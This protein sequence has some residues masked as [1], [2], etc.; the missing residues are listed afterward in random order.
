MNDSQQTIS[1][2]QLYLKL[3]VYIKPL[4][5]MFAIGIAGNIVFALTQPAFAEL[6]RYITNA[7]G[8]DPLARWIVPAALI[9]IF[10]VRGLGSFIGDYGFARVAFGVVHAL[11]LDLFNHIT[12]LPNSAI[13][14]QNS[15]TLVSRVTYDTLQ[16]TDTVT[17]AIKTA[18]REGAIVIVLMAYLL[19]INW[20]ATSVFILIAPLVLWVLNKISKRLRKLGLRIQNSMGDLTHLCA[21]MINNFRVMRVFGGEDYE[22]KRFNKGSQHNARQNIKRRTTAAAAG[23]LVQLLAVIALAVLVFLAL[24]LMKENSAGEILAYITAAAIMPQSMRKLG[25][26]L[27]SI[28]K[29][30]AAADSIFKQLDEKQEPDLGTGKTLSSLSG[31][32]QFNDVGFTYHNPQADA[33]DIREA[34]QKIA[35]D[36]VSFTVKA[37]ET[38]ALVG[39]SGSGKTTLINLIPRFLCHQSGTITIDNHTLEDISLQSLRRQIALVN[40]NITLFNDTLRNN[41]AYGDM[42]AAAEEAI[43]DAAKKAYAWEFIEQLPDGLNT[44]VGENGARLS[45]GQRQRIAIARALLK[46]AAILILDEATSALDTESERH[47]QNA[48]QTASTGRTTFIIAHRL[49]TIENADRIIVMDQGKVVEQ[50]SH[51]ELL[52]QHGHYAQLYQQGFNKEFHQD[53]PT[54]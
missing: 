47:I 16:V 21:E 13:E 29:G 28:Q 36:G 19:W 50:G 48:L 53:E 24:T 44:L 10:I 37:G 32:I 11:R 38:I 30:I 46:D 5:P 34:A 20:L 54:H 45:G 52:S 8:V 2:A 22:R 3:L 12:R 27:G 49:S 26:I 6:M 4:W 15:S 31:N 42:A 17:N 43:I 9:G 41:I 14:N 35:L 7:V 39:R 51:K 1:A 25:S 33:Q 40:Q 18:V 23:P